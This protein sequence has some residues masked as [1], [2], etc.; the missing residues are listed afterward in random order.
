[1]RKFNYLSIKKIYESGVLLSENGELTMS[2]ETNYLIKNMI[3][4]EEVG[5]DIIASIVSIKTVKK[6]CQNGWFDL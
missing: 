4:H 2:S 3:C 1:M 5:F 6:I